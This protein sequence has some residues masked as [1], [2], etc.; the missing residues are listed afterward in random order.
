LM[1]NFHPNFSSILW[2]SSMYMWKNISH[3]IHFVT[4]IHVHVEK[5]CPHHSFCDFHPCTCGKIFPTSF[6]CGGIGIF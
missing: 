2:L 5:Y 3:I 1:F 4:F 6:I